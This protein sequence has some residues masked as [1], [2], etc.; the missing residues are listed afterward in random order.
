[1]EYRFCPAATYSAKY[2]DATWHRLCLVQAA[3]G[4]TRAE[5]W[6]RSPAAGKGGLTSVAGDLQNLKK[7]RRQR[8]PREGCGWAGARDL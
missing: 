2:D 1:M 5:A 4:R 6:W 8:R 3:A 7:E